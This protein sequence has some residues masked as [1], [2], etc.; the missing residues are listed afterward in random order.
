L[1][2]ANTS[3]Y[4]YWKLAWSTPTSG[5]DAGMISLASASS[6]SAYTVTPFYYLIKH[7]SKNI[8][9]GYHRVDATSSNTSLVTTAFVSPDNSKMTIVVVNDGSTQAKVYFD[10]TGKTINSVSANQSISG[11]SY[12]KAVTITSST[13]SILLPAKSITTVVLGI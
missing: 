7:F 10:A 5:T 2:Y 11:S 9:N 12:Y 13:K 1:L 8:D 3:G 6:S 4:I